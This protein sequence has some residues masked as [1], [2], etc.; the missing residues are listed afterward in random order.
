MLGIRPAILAEAV[1]DAPCDERVGHDLSDHG[2]GDEYL[3]TALVVGRQVIT[4]RI[5]H[6]V[7]PVVSASSRQCE[8]G[9]CCQSAHVEFTP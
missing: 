6:A 2:G 3:D 1:D 8:F 5:P 7:D 4:R 9:K